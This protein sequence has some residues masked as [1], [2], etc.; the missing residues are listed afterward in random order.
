MRV[1]CAVEN[2]ITYVKRLL[3]SLLFCLRRNF[4]FHFKTRIQAGGVIKYGAERDIGPKRE[5]VTGDWRTLHN[6]ELHY[7]YC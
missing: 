5:D 7:L 3:L 6:E 1:L 2:H 4:N